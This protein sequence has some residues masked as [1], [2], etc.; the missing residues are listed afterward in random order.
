MWWKG[1]LCLSHGTNVSSGVVILF[2]SHLNVNILSEME[3]EKGCILMVKAKIE[4]QLFIFINIYAPNKGSDKI[5]MFRKLGEFLKSYT[6]DGMLIIG[7]GLE[8]YS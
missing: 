7:G 3:I 8:L 2:S 1:K 4:N 5:I 6:L